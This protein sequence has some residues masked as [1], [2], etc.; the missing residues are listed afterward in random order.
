M[1]R[2]EALRLIDS[3]L[4]RP[5]AIYD[6]R[7]AIAERF[8]DAPIEMIDTATFHLC[9]DGIDAALVWLATIEQ[10]L[11]KPDNGL[12]YGATWHLLY[13]LYNWQQF[14]ALLPLGKLGIAKHLEDVIALLDASNPDAAKQ[15]IVHLIE[16]IRGDLESPGFG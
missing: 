5:D 12:D 6:A 14:E 4:A 9:V 10:F 8:P 1:K 3:L 16:C 11:Q 2:D 7:C 13:H 15:T